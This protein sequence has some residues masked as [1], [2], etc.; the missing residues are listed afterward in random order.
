M[1]I[2]YILSI[3]ALR[4]SHY[5]LTPL[6]S[7]PQLQSPSMKRPSRKAGYQGVPGAYSEVAALKVCDAYL[8]QFC[9]TPSMLPFSG[10]PGVRSDAM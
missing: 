7:P 8:T 3:H 2:E 4:R 1:L 9:L 10:L 5:L 6:N